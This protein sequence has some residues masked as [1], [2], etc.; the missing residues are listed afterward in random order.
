MIFFLLLVS[1]GKEE[2]GVLHLESEPKNVLTFV[3]GRQVGNLTPISLKLAVG[4]HIINVKNSDYGEHE[5]KLFIGANSIQKKTISL[6]RFWKPTAKEAY[7][8]IMEV[9]NKMD[10]KDYHFDIQYYYP[11]EEF[12]CYYPDQIIKKIR[13][14]K[15]LDINNVEKMVKPSKIKLNCLNGIKCT[16]ENYFSDNPQRYSSSSLTI[17]FGNADET[18]M[19]KVRIAFLFLLEYMN[20]NDYDRDFKLKTK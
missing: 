12:I 5:F 9:Y 10:T 8:Y 6:L 7:D 17:P 3:D 2:T 15:N 20:K 13:L 1:C 18:T 19:K 4:E 16:K 14:E 11:D